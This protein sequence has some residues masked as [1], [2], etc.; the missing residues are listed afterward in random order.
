MKKIDKFLFEHFD[1]GE[2]QEADM[3]SYIAELLYDDIC[4]GDI[5]EIKKLLKKYAKYR[6]KQ[7]DSAFEWDHDMEEWTGDYKPSE[8]KI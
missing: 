1:L 5:D 8:I 4:N 3:D 6:I 7:L 2:G